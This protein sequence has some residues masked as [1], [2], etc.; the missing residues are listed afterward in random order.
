[1][2]TRYCEM[3]GKYWFEQKE[4]CLSQ[5]SDCLA[6]L[7]AIGGMDA[8]EGLKSKLATLEHA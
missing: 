8:L 3:Q 5:R 7:P 1:M 2:V 4:S 6:Q